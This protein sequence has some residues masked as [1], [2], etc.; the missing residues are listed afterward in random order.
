VEKAMSESVDESDRFQ[1]VKSADRTLEVL[2][3]IAV[4]SGRVTLPELARELG[5]PKS[6]LYGILKTL[7]KRQWVESDETGTRF[8]LGLRALLIGVSFIESDDVV[9]Q[10][11]PVLDWLSA[12]SGGEAVHLGRLDGPNIVYLAK[13]ESKHAL[14]MYSA[15]GR[16]LPAHATALGKVLLA[17]RTDKEVI[18]LLNWP[19]GKLTESTITRRDALLKDLKQV[20]ERG[21]AEDREENAEGLRCFAVALDVT[22]PAQDAISF[23]IPVFR[24]NS[25]LEEKVLMLLRQASERVHLGYRISG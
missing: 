16:R 18:S 5:I 10:V 2:E 20:R 3:A 17:Q 13:R 12:E 25:E 14:R 11:A 8:G 23:S 15:V 7:A 1:P 22:R 21:Y 6:S 19:L 4:K 9:A 24:M